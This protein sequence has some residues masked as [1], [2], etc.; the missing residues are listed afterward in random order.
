MGNEAG[1]EGNH[2]RLNRFVDEGHGF[3]RADNRQVL[4]GF[5]R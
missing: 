2:S 1:G 5:S 3:S 4:D